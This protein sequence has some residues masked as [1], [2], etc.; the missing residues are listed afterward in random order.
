MSRTSDEMKGVTHLGEKNTQ[1]A[2]DYAPELLETFENKHPDKDYW[3]KLTVPSSRASV[4]LRGSQISRRSRSPTCP[5]GAWSR[6][7]R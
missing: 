1:Y 4:R 3:V 6:A 5:S 7:N 2:V